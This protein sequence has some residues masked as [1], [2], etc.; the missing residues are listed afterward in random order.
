MADVTSALTG[1]APG[2][3]LVP[4]PKADPRKHPE[5]TPEKLASAIDDVHDQLSSIPMPQSDPRGSDP[6]ASMRDYGKYPAS[7]AEKASALA[8]SIRQIWFGAKD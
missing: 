1:R 4:E 6:T 7:F 3:S 5:G 2:K 8:G